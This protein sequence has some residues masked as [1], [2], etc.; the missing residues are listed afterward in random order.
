MPWCASGPQAW[1]RQHT[2]FHSKCGICS[3]SREIERLGCQST[4]DKLLTQVP[5][6]CTTGCPKHWYSY[7]SQ[8]GVPDDCKTHSTQAVMYLCMPKTNVHLPPRRRTSRLARP[9]GL[10]ALLCTPSTHTPGRGATPAAAPAAAAATPS[11]APPSCQAN[12]REFSVAFA[13]M[14]SNSH[15]GQLA[16]QRMTCSKG[17]LCPVLHHTEIHR[18]MM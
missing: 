17:W 15:K 11:A 6:T 3:C 1:Q 9:V 14:Y 7:E 13:R 8:L 4:V 5:R 16:L 2:Y 10:A 12:G 18:T